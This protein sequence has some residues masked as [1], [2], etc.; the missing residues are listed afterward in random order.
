MNLSLH[1]ITKYSIST[2]LFPL[3][4]GYTCRNMSVGDVVLI[5]YKSKSVPGSYRLGRVIDV[6]VDEE[7]LVRTCTVKY[8]LI[9]PGT[10]ISDTVKKEV[11][12]AIL[13]LV[14]ILP[15]EEQ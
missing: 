4:N 12:V 14:L 7:G 10:S 9:K 6:E 2:P 5:C 1:V 15:I 13:R 3:V 11:C 8:C